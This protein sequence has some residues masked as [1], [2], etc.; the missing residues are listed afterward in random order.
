MPFLPRARNLGVVVA[1]IAY[2]LI[3]PYGIFGLGPADSLRIVSLSSLSERASRASATTESAPVI[4]REYRAVKT[5]AGVRVM[6]ERLVVRITGDDRVSFL[7]GMCSADIK[8]L[9]RGEVAPALFLTDHA[10]V[11]AACFIYADR[12]AFVLESDRRQWPQVRAHLEKFLVADDVEMEELETVGVIDIEGVQ[13]ADVIRQFAGEAAAS[14]QPWR[15]NAEARA[16]NVPR[17]GPAAFTLM[18]ER[19][20]AAAEVEPL[21][22]QHPGLC[23]VSAETL[24]ILRVENGVAAIGVDTTEKTLALEARLERSISFSKGCYIGQE[25]VER[26]T[27][28]GALKRR[29]YGLQIEDGR[30]P[31]KGGAVL[32]AG[33]EVGTLTSVVRSPALG[34]IG[35]AILHHSAW[36]EGIAVA[37]RDPGGELSAIVRELPFAKD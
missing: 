25:T 20:R 1:K 21:K 27:A 17:F 23:D 29:L 34:I 4:E 16:A 2:L 14:L 35:L 32:L 22:A 28:R 11:V 19:S 9:K 18:V 26:A 12:D 10:H 7:H 33:K 31:A 30:L 13:A 37:V 15:Y 36:R 24:E 8:G 5:G 3:S 6:E